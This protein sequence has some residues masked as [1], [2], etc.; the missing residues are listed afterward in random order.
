L[1][2]NWWR[3]KFL[4]LKSR[5]KRWW[6][7]IVLTSILS[8]MLVNLP[9]N[10]IDLNYYKKGRYLYFQ[11]LKIAL[12]PYIILLMLKLKSEPSEDRFTR[13]GVLK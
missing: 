9:Y 6:W 12:F 13:N 5:R 3:N 11:I 7:T 8:R 4:V 2:Q 10:D 1:I